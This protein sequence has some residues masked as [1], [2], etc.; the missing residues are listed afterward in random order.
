M[1]ND[2][3]PWSHKKGLTVKVWNNN[4][5]SAIVQLKRR[6]NN[7][8]ITKELRKRKHYDPP[9]VVKQR[10]LAEAKLRWRKKSDLINE[11]VR[12]KRRQKKSRN[13]RTNLNTKNVTSPILIQEFPAITPNL[14]LP[15]Y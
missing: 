13:E 10:K 4:I 5:D 3:F 1:I 15:K 6:L 7:E 8:G 12:P 14:R 9:S 11:I 2:E